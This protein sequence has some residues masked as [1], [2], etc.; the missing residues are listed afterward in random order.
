VTPS[1]FAQLVFNGIAIGLVYVFMA[2]GFNLILSV[3]GIFFITFGMFY[4]LGAYTTWWLAVQGHIPYFAS[5][6]ISTVAMAVGGVILYLLVIRRIRTGEQG[7]LRV[8]IAS[9]MLVTLLT[10]FVLHMF[11]T[12]PRG[13][14]PVFK[15]HWKIAGVVI[16]MDRV[17]VILISIAIL[18]ALH[19]FLNRTRIGRGMRTV[20]FNPDVAALLGVNSEKVF[21]TTIA[22][23]LGLVGFAGGLMAPILGV[24]ITMGAAG[25]MVLLVIILGGI[26]SMIGSI[27]SGIL[28]GIV[29]A[30][31]QFYVSAGVGQMIFFAVVG[32]FF[33][34]RPGGMFGKPPPDPVDGVA[35]LTSAK[36][37]SLRGRKIWIAPL[38]VFALALAIPQIGLSSYYMHLMILIVIFAVT[39]MTF[40]FGMRSGMI[41][42][43]AASFWGIGAYATG[44]LMTKAGFTFW[45]ALP[46]AMVVSFV[47]ALILA[48]VIC[49]FAGMSG[50]MFGIVFASI[51]PVAFGTFEIFGKQSGLTGI[52]GITDLGPIHFGSKASYYYL[53][54]AFAIIGMIIMLAFTKAWTGRSWLGLGSSQKLAESVGIDPF[55]YRIINFAIMS[56][57]PALLGT[58]YACY[59]G[60]I[61]PVTFGPFIG[62]N[63][64]IVAFV[65]GLGYLVA[66][67]IVG[68]LFM[69]L[70]PELLRVAGSY[71][72]IITAI[73]I[74]LVI[75]FLPGG[76][77]GSQ[78]ARLL[79]AGRWVWRHAARRPAAA[80]VP[81]G[82]GR[83]ARADRMPIRPP[84]APL[85]SADEEGSE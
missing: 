23:G 68:A 26:G 72:P 3:T 62:I 17:A 51:V 46:L 27:L 80:L 31:S 49:R 20:A 63:F 45:Q 24:D 4:A 77:I 65:G 22:V 10:Q 50:M 15:G 55:G 7:M 25:F 21:I 58:A 78:D 43:A 39:G 14:P 16:G 83:P 81:A 53:T 66:G 70:L 79:A 6:A 13:L 36:I 38:V 5:V 60:A 9:I 29:V 35:S 18:L 64:Q 56:V 11:G 57:I 59:L 75:M 2:S 54:L 85:T 71:E 82:V 33:F 19:F 12:S 69:T 61:Q 48:A 28:L 34:F 1:I 8:L 41:N 30:F 74:I 42:V 44:L 32:I 47:L 67:P 40:T 76:I 37:K 73:I 84:A 52:P